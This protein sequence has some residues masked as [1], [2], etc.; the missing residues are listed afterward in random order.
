MKNFTLGAFEAGALIGM[1]TFVREAGLKELHKGHI[2]A[3][4]VTPAQRGK[5]IA[6]ALIGRLLSEAAEDQSLEQILLAVATQQEIAVKVYRAF[7]FEIY[8]TEPRG[9][10]VGTDYVDEH[11]MILFLSE[12]RWNS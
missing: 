9:L 10:K 2:Y 12:R 6:R 8:G 5:G 1:A 3:V 7:G 11:H 4:Y